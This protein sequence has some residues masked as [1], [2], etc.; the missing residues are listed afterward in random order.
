MIDTNMV[1]T[2]HMH[3]RGGEHCCHK[4]HLNMCA[5]GEGDCDTDNDCAG[6]LVC[7]T[8]NC[9]NF[10]TLDG[11]WDAEDDCCERQCTPEHPCQEGGGHCNVDADCENLLK[12]GD[13]FC[14]NPTYF[15]RLEFPR[16]SETFFTG[17]D[18][19]CYRHCNKKYHLCAEGEVGCHK[20]EDCAVGLYCKKDV[21]QPYCT[22]HDEC[23]TSSGD[24]KGQ[25][26]CGIN[27]ICKN[28]P[29]SFIC[30]CIPGFTDFQPFSG[31]ID[32]DECATNTHKCGANSVCFNTIGSY[33]CGCQPG[34]TG[35]GMAGCTDLDE[36]AN[37]TWN[38]C[39]G[40]MFPKGISTE[41]C[42]G[43]PRQYTDIGSH[44]IFDGE[45]HTFEF[46]L[47][48][49]VSAFDF[50]STDDNIGYRIFHKDT[51]KISSLANN[52]AST[53]ATVPSPSA[54][55]SRI[56]TF[57]HYFVSFE[58]KQNMVIKFGAYEDA[59]VTAEHETSSPFSVDKFRLHSGGSG[60]SY[61]R[62]IRK[63]GS[64]SV[65]INNVGSYTCVEDSEERVAI[66]FG[67]HTTDGNAYP[68]QFTV[69]TN[70]KLTCT[71]HS[72]T[73]LSGRRGHGK[74]HFR[75]P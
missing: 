43:G 60:C 50:L 37:A 47:A 4:G 74:H 39:G 75:E 14:L 35:N 5:E 8:N 41:T 56:E 11:L 38:N 48:G 51:S 26:Y 16:N 12:C 49:D 55:R 29:G 2:L 64:V 40:G 28:T 61:W 3:C 34:Y 72:I 65:C 46:S 59:F 33:V 1:P 68:P 54:F 7:G 71:H 19:C 53:I 21:D 36:C 6:A 13:N 23:D 73:D 63:Q 31:C 20:D 57:N 9:A 17:S 24:F 32:V 52:K 62:N 22:D 66:G 67:G 69:V 15:P 42:P 10:R 18:N 58:K 70:D 30:P 45:I 44:N 25:V 27:T